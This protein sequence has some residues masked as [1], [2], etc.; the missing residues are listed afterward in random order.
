[1]G[2]AVKEIKRSRGRPKKE[3]TKIMRVPVSLVDK[4]Q[5]LID[6]VRNHD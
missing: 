1:M 3:P 4:V 2:R 6:K 5:K